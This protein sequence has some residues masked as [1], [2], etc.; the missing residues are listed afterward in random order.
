MLSLVPDQKPTDIHSVDISNVYGKTLE[1][2]TDGHSYM[3]FDVTPELAELENPYDNSNRDGVSYNW[4]MPT[5]T[6]TITAI[7]A[8]LRWC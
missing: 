6:N 3:N 5:T 4:T 7:S 2:W 8:V 1:A